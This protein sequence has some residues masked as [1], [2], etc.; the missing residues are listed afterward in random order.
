MYDEELIGLVES[1]V[2]LCKDHTMLI[3]QLM[4]RVKELEA[5]VLSLQTPSP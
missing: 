3:T 4:K 5:N 2:L 1:L